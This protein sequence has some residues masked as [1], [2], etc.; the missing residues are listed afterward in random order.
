MTT[1]IFKSIA[2]VTGMKNDDD[3]RKVADILE[4]GFGDAVGKMNHTQLCSAIETSYMVLVE[5]I[6]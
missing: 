2:T 4:A 3:I 1:N 5:V 6:S